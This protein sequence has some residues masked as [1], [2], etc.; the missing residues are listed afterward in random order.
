MNEPYQ[1][2]L[3]PRKQAGAGWGQSLVI[4][5][6]A[7]AVTGLVI[8]LFLPGGQSGRESTATEP[9]ALFDMEELK[10]LAETLERNQLYGQAADAWRQVAEDSAPQDDARAELLFR[11]GKNEF[12]AGAYGPAVKYLLAAERAD[13]AGRWKESIN[14]MVLEGL[15][16]MGLEEARSQ[17]ARQRISLA[18]DKHAIEGTVV[19]EVGGE[20]ITETEL[21]QAGRRMVEQQLAGR[22]AFMSPEQLDQLIEQQIER[23]QQPQAKRQLLQ[24]VLSRELLYREALAAALADDKDVRSQLRDTRKQILTEAFVEQYLDQNMSVTETDIA[25]AYEANKDRYVEP[26]AV[27][28]AAVV[29]QDEAAQA[30]VDQALDAGTN[31]DEVR[32]QYSTM[33]DRQEQDDPFAGWIERGGWVPMVKEP[34]AAAAHLFALSAG[35][36]GGKWFE[37]SDGQ[38]VRFKLIEHR[39]E[40]TLPLDECRERVEKDLRQ[41]K[42]RDLIDQLQDKLQNKYEVVVHEEALAT[43]PAK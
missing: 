12:L 17:Q 8:V 6:I 25:N 34:K 4:A 40:R 9:A 3:P 24:M 30:E 19:A 38:W 20:P 42:Q 1:F 15:S 10:E 18:D 13:E 11:I 41:Q 43:Q 7:A 14:K 39:P 23:F 32:E 21:L 16:A 33:K 26:E 31:F 27:Q 22:R 5:L 37:T 29:V 2:D 35:E 28:V 36:V